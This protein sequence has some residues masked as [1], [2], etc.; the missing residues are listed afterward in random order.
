[1]IFKLSKSILNII[2]ILLI[3]K[4]KLINNSFYL[5]N[6]YIKLFRI[7]KILQILNKF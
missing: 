5:I 7:F 1:M 3:D 6:N 4:P 2:I